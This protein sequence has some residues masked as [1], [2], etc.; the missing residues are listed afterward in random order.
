MS[1]IQKQKGF[2]EEKLFVL[3]DYVAVELSNTELIKNFYLSDIGYFPRAKYHYRERPEGCDAHILIYCESGSGWVE[4]E[5]KSFPI[6]NRQLAII[7]AG[8]PH[9]YG[10]SAESPWSIY[11]FHLKGENVASYLR[12]FGLGRS[13]VTLSLA[14]QTGI[15]ECFDLCYGLMTDKPYSIPVQVHVSQ[16]IGQ[17]I[18]TIG[19]NA[20]GSSRSRKRENDLERAMHLMRSRLHGN[21]TLTELAS[22]T[23][24][25]KQ[26]LIYLFK[27]ETG[28]PPVDYY[29]RLK[30]QKAGQQLCLTGLSIKEIA[31]DFG[32]PDPYYFSRMF[33]KIMGVSPS[34]FQNEPKG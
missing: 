31:A 19:L 24:I 5:G 21:L 16:T 15:M 8:V 12:L 32:F 18:G 27:Q 20:A 30:M 33:K 22:H 34:K 6:A 11:W 28:F 25:S 9:R 17:M 4:M 14:L 10:A 7:P 23:G 13:P 2:P 26:H 1:T 3:P 29:L